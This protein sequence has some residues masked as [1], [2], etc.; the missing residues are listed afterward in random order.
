MNDQNTTSIK[1]IS[2]NKLKFFCGTVFLLFSFF[3]LIS[4]F[5]FS[6]NDAGWGVS[7]TYKVNNF[8]GYPG[9][10]VSGLILKELGLY[11]ALMFFG[12]F[13]LLGLKLLSQN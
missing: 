6:P 2:K 7:S 1:K 11:S 8:F 10:F 3:I 9:S 13:I 12:T 5:T 4:I